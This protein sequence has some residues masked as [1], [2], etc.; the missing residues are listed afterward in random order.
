MKL[1]APAKKRI[2]RCVTILILTLIVALTYFPY[3]FMLLSSLKNNAEIAAHPFTLTFPLRFENYVS[4]FGK[5]M[6]YLKNSILVSGATVAGTVLTGTLSAYVFARFR[7]PGKN[8]LYMFVLAFLMVPSVLTLIPQYVLVSD[9]KLIGTFWAVILPA[10]ATAQIQFIVVLRPFIEATPRELSEAA[11]LDG[12]SQAQLFRHVIYPLIKS[13]IISLALI[14]FLNSWND[15]IWPMLTLSAND[16]LKT[17]TLGLYSYR[18]LQQILYG[19]M[20]AG[21]FLASIP[22]IIFFSL[23]MRNFIGGITSGAVKG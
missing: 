13:T 19:P 4:S 17:I 7:F 6:K 2:S 18:D 10:I 14:A 12:A 11:I 3:Y 9:M 1:N 15:F 21:F 16:E 8:F 5:I 22:M 23:N 20:F